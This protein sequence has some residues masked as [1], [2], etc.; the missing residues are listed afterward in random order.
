M[1]N[2]RIIDYYAI[3]AVPPTVDLVG[4][5]AA[6]TRLSDELVRRSDID[7][8]AAPALDRLNEAYDVLANPETRRQYDEVLF[9]TEL[10]IYR[11]QQQA[12]DRRRKLIRAAII[13]ALA[14]IVLIQSAA[15]LYIGWDYVDGGLEVVLGP[16]WPGQA[17]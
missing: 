3:L 9:Q 2:P 10:A 13:T 17:A 8:S 11:R 12:E 16:L 5:E 14:G 6:Y 7:E 1:A 4:I 15:L